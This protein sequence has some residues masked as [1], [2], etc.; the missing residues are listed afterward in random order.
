MLKVNF[1]ISIIGST[2]KE[3]SN[4]IDYKDINIIT[5]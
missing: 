5:G 3:N 2:L 4:K 1:C